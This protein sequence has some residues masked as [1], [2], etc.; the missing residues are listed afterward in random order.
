MFGR[1]EVDEPVSTHEHDLGWLAGGLELDVEASVRNRR[2]V[3]A[4]GAHVKW[5]KWHHHRGGWSRTACCQW[6]P[7][8]RWKAR[9]RLKQS[10]FDDQVGQFRAQW[11]VTPHLMTRARS[12]WSRGGAGWLFLVLKKTEVCCAVECHALGLTEVEWR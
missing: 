12:R 7:Y 11:S 4:D 10:H 8:R 9:R 5:V 6:E 3:I 1:T 2:A